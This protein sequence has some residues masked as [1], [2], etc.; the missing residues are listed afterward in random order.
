MRAYPEGRVAAV[1][2][3]ETYSFSKPEQDEIILVAGVGIEGDAHA[4]ITVKHRGRVIADPTQ[5]NLRQVHLIHDELFDELRA[6]GYEVRPGQLGENVTTHGIDLLGLPRGTI[7]RFGPT[8][9]RRASDPSAVV[10]VTERVSL[11]DPPPPRTAANSSVAGASVAGASVAGPSVAGPSV[12]GSSVAGSSVAGPSVA[13]SIAADSI[14]AV[15]A[16]AEQATL[17]DRTSNAV[18]ALIEAARR[19]G[20]PGETAVVVT[21]LRNPCQQINVFRPGLLKRVIGQDQDGN[22][23]RKGGV[24][25]VVLYGGPIRPGDPVTV[26]PPPQPH[27]PLEPV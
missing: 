25:A 1:S 2:R 13:D 12:A 22:L 8:Q 24:M 15:V 20:T 23:V 18:A 7:L 14:A 6:E 3:N 26:E 11:T 19:A 21:G 4:G 16:A 9:V 27:L 5:P 17:N 10:P